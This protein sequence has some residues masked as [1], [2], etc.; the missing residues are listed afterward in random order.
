MLSIVVNLIYMIS[1]IGSSSISVN[2]SKDGRDFFSPKSLAALLFL[3]FLSRPPKK[4]SFIYRF[5][6]ILNFFLWVGSREKLI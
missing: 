1:F 2:F 5:F 6:Y 3:E 4:K